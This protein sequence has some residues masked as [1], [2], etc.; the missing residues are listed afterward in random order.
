MA[1]KGQHKQKRAHHQTKN[2]NANKKEHI[3]KQKKEYANKKECVTKQKKKTQAK[4]A[5]HKQKKQNANKKAN[6]P[7]HPPAF[8]NWPQQAISRLPMDWS[9]HLAQP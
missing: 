1:Q 6:T 7:S 2:E 9:M 8:D 4:I 5:Q 3:T